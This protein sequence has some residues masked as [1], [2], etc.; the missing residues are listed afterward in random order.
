M[1]RRCSSVSG[2]KACHVRRFGVLVFSA[3]LIL[4]CT[5][6]P[7]AAGGD[8]IAPVID[9]SRVRVFDITLNPGRLWAAPKGANFAEMFLVGGR[10]RTTGGDGKFSVASRKSGDVVYV[11]Q[12]TDQ[13]LEVISNSPARVVVVELKDPAVPPLPNNSGYVLAFPRPGAKRVLENDRIVAWHS[14]W[15]LGVPT[16]VHYHDKDVVIVF[17]ESGSIKSTKSNG[18]STIVDDE[19]GVI[20]FSKADRL[21][22]EELVKGRESAIVL[23]LK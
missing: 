3:S 8:D 9:N 19:L 20:R 18:D 17:M 5:V 14:T 7:T 22:S 23:E 16:A 13:K 21:H 1:P 4:F 10:V 12:G 2:I 11:K 15:K 6:M